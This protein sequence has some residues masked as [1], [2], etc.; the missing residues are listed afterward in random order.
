MRMNRNLQL[1]GGVA[2][3]YMAETWDGGGSLESMGV[4][5]ADYMFLKYVLI[6]L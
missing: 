6:I 5:L 1:M 3:E 4:T 2:L